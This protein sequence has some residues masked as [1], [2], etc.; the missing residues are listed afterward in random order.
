M[1]YYWLPARCT[2][3]S[4]APARCCK[5]LLQ[6][7]PAATVIHVNDG[8]TMAGMPITAGKAGAAPDLA[9]LFS[10]GAIW[11]HTRPLAV[12]GPQQQV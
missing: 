12:K 4:R 1:V 8:A 6:Q 10:P 3:I 2:K 11:A 9:A 5:A 7:Q